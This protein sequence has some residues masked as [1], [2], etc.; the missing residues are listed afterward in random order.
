MTM[1]I[2]RTATRSPLQGLLPLWV[3]IGVYALLLAVGRGL[4]NDPDTYWQITLGQWMLDHQAVPRVDIYS[5]TMHGQP[6]ISTQ[7][8]AQVAYALAYGVAGWAGPVV[9]AAASASLAIALLAGFLDARLPR[10]A[11]LVILA[12]TLALMAA[13]M[14]ARPH[15]LAMPVMVAWVAGL[16]SAM[17][18]KTVPSFWLLSLMALWANLHGG[19]VLGLALIGPIALD[20]IWH[21]PKN[22]QTRMLLHWALFGLAALA[23][24][25]I[26]PYGWEAL[27][28]ARRILSL[29]AAL[30]LIGEWRP[31]NFGHA[32]PLELS[33]LAAFAFVL[34]RGITLPPM[35]IVLVLGFTYMALSHV[36]NAEVLALL[37][38]L[39]LAKPV[40]EQLGRNVEDDTTSP[41]R[42]LLAGIALC[43]L[44]GTVVVASVRQYAPSER[45]APVAAVDAL[46]KLNLGRVFNDYDFGGYLIWRGVPT[47]IDGRTE[48]FGEKLMVDHN[49]A[50]G[51]AEPDNLFRLLK[52]YNIEATFMRTESAATKL[53]DRMD[54]WEKVYSD[55]LAT[56]HLRKGGASEKVREE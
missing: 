15:L 19:F 9:L 43:V 11:T 8:L 14:V 29:G 25:C 18:R 31:A 2:A 41:N 26:T 37:A 50:S 3:G 4:L 24:S 46:K 33:V 12:A 17:D 39:V 27:L 54:G 38:P 6:W 13:H 34:W 48:L 44:A 7:W 23:A 56:I 32:G 47:F 36:R 10:T 30:A 51:L 5:F 35:R 21:A 55:D 49:N 52:D 22:Q 45:A 53:L 28:A 20:A 42:W 40:G 16:V 1:S